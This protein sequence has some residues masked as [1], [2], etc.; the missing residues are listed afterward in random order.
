MTFS[1]DR[2]HNLGLVALNA[3]FPFSLY[4]IAHILAFHG[5]Y[6]RNPGSTDKWSALWMLR[7]G[8][9]IVDSP[10]QIRYSVKKYVK[11]GTW[12]SLSETYLK[13]SRELRVKRSF[14]SKCG[15]YAYLL[16]VVSTILVIR[17][18]T[19]WDWHYKLS[20]DSFVWAVTCSITNLLLFLSISKC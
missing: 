12:P 16:L 2:I 17:P 7:A 15:K 10:K 13:F 18:H 1:L 19:I 11:A 20:K 8:N 4:Y 5:R 6:N 3:H 14:S 9:F